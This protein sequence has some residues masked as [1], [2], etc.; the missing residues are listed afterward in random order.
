MK[1]TFA[2]VISFFLL[3]ISLSAQSSVLGT[4]K[5]VD[6]VTND[7]KYHV[8]MFEFE[9]RM[10]GKVVKMVKVPVDQKCT[11]CPSDLKNQPVLGMV[12]MEKLLLSGG[13]YKN[14]RMLDPQNGRW[15]SCQM[16]LKEEDPDVLVVRG[17]LGFIYFTQ[18]WYRVK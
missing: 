15:Y 4:W 9:G 14:G 5:V 11:L 2:F 16:W 13:F 7:V 17:F 8:Q 3:V 12:V 10:Y 1:K 6:N 18:Y